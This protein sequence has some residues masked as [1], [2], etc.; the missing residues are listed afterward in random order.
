MKLAPRGLTAFV[1]ILTGTLLL[2]VILCAGCRPV[3]SPAV[4]PASGS[5][6]LAEGDRIL[7]LAP[8][9]DDEVLGAGG[10]LREAVRRGLPTRVVF[11]TNGDSNEWSFLAYRKRPV[12]R[13]RAVLAMG[14]MRGQE[15]LAATAALGVPA[16]DVS[17]L[18]YPDYGTL[19]I[20]RAHWGGR[21]PD[22]GRL[23]R[24]RAVPYPTAFRPGAPYKGEE[25]LAD[26]E[27]ILR[28]FKPTR[29][30]VSHPA[31]HH[32]D[33]AALYLFTRVALWDLQG[34]IT[35]TVHPFLVH[36]PGWPRTQGLPGQELS[37][38]DRLL[39]GFHWQS[40]D[41]DP[42]AVTAKRLALAAHRTQYGYS[43]SRL[44]PFVRPNELYGD[45]TVPVLAAGD[46]AVDLQ[47]LT[48][49]RVR[50]RLEIEMELQ[51]PLTEGST[52]SLSALG[53]RPD[54]PFAAMPKLEVRIEPHVW[55]VRDQRKLL[56][57]TAAWGGAQDRKLVA[58][59]PLA[60][61]NDPRRLF[62]Q[63]RTGSRRSELG[64]TPWWIVELGPGTA[65]QR[66]A[67]GAREVRGT[68]Q[69]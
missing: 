49:R 65:E 2:A 32:P 3:A 59:I 56:P 4:R 28:D 47:G 24:A 34:E 14:T 23:T 27:T 39:A 61:L 26:L 55:T 17:L 13:P 46:G 19:A 7:V 10:V 12:I 41:L 57:R 36:Y 25:I 58:R 22:R 66:A 5:M 64:Q 11:L 31:D 18:G 21:P 43:T 54:V 53:Y 60:S 8:H 16:R 68:A 6:Q 30:F 40:R 51:E 45:L 50:D 62:L 20:W 1:H 63:V 9:P 67:V 15:A 33:H 44:L 35:A 42:E 29:I 52:V 69:R 48:V 37:P 38:P